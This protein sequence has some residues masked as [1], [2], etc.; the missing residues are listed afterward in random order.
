MRLPWSD[1]RFHK[2]RN[3]EDGESYQA[4]ETRSGMTA[5]IRVYKSHLA[6]AVTDML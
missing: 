5:T 4:K 1:S 6:Q 2:Q 3:L